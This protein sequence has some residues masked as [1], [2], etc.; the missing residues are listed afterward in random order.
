MA[1]KNDARTS[2]APASDLSQ[3]PLPMA[4]TAL[5]LQVDIAQFYLARCS[6]MPPMRANV[7]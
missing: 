3:Q 6:P 1:F 4:L 7:C 2:G 5:T